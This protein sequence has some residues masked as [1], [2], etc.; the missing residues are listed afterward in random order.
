MGSVTIAGGG[1]WSSPTG[2]SFFPSNQSLT[3]TYTPSN[4]DLI[5]G[6]V[7]ITFTTTNNSGCSAVSDQMVITYTDA[8]D[9]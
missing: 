8:P 3:P 2:G 6:S 4:S 7:T 9:C 1:Q 5:N